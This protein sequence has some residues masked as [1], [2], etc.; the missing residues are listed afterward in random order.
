L[1]GEVEPGEAVPA[2]AG[3]IASQCSMSAVESAAAPGSTSVTQT[4]SW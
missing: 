2:V 4:P 3:T 1:C